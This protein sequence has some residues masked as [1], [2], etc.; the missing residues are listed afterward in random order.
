MVKLRI[1]TDV[2]VDAMT[3]DVRFLCHDLYFLLFLN[4]VLIVHIMERHSLYQRIAHFV[5]S[6]K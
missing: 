2:V 3:V 1:K 6:L 5:L 4:L